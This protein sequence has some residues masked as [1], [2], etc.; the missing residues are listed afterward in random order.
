M[1]LSPATT[2]AVEPVLVISGTIAV[3]DFSPVPA[4]VRR[5]RPYRGS[6]AAAPSAMIDFGTSGTVRLMLIGGVPLAK[7]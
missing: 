4:G 7:L 1:D 6:A 2:G 3:L 5:G